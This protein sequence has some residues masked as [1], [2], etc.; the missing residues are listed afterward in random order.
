MKFLRKNKGIGRALIDLTP[1]LD[2]IFIFLMVV[3]CFNTNENEEA[4]NK[5]LDAEEK[6]QEAEKTRNERIAELETM[7]EQLD[8]IKNDSVNYTTIYAE[9][10]P[11]NRKHRTIHIKFNAEPEYT[12]TLNPSNVEEAWEDCEKYITERID[13]EKPMIVSI[14]NSKMLYR[15][16]QKIEEMIDEINANGSGRLYKST[17][18]IEE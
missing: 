16:E 10:D 13:E 5:L 6:L 12:S 14:K 15:D 3:L 17:P 2:V 7:Q 9:Y 1:L 18:E 11:N 8:N 4:Q